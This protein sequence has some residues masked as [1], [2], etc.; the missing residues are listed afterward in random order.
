MAAHHPLLPPDWRYPLAYF[1]NRYPT[2]NLPDPASIGNAVG[3]LSVHLDTRHFHD[4]HSG[5]AMLSHHLPYIVTT[6]HKRLRQG[7][8]A[9]GGRRKPPTLSP[10]RLCRATAGRQQAASADRPLVPDDEA[11]NAPADSADLRSAGRL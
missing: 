9:L 1:L 10:P 8:R 4:D 11:R 6:I 2:L 7:K 3:V 5:A